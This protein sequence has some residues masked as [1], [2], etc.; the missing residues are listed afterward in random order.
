MAADDKPPTRDELPDLTDLLHELEAERAHDGL[1]RAPE[2]VLVD[3][4]A[5][6]G[7]AV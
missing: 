5:S 1:R 7:R 4:A 6:P 3:A 2:A